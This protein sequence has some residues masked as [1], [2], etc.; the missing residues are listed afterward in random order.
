MSTNHESTL[1]AQFLRPSQSI[2]GLPLRPLSVGVLLAAQTLGIKLLIGSAEEL[3]QAEKNFELLEV[4]FLLTA[5]EETIKTAVAAGREKFRAEFVMP[6]SFK[7]PVAELGKVAATLK[8]FGTDAEAA[9]VE[10]VE[11]PNHP[12][13]DAPLPPPNS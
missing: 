9:A 11:K 1:N 10:V 6:F 2:A 3:T 12:D 8:D 13:S 7:I 5:E 4:L